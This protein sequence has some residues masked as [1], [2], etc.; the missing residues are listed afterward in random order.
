MHSI[1]PRTLLAIA[2]LAVTLVST[3]WAA[4]LNVC[5]S[6]TYKTIQSAVDSAQSGDTVL[7]Q[8][9]TY[10]EQVIVGTNGLHLLAAALPGQAKLKCPGDPNDENSPTVGIYGEVDQ[11]TVAGFDIS[12]CFNAIVASPPYSEDEPLYVHRW[13]IA[14]NILHGNGVGI[15]TILNVGSSVLS[16]TFYANWNSNVMSFV[17]QQGT[18]AGN[19]VKAQH[20]SIGINL[21]YGMEM[22]VALNV[23]RGATIGIN[24]SGTTDSL[25]TMNTTNGGGVGVWMQSDSTGN[26]ITNSIAKQNNKHAECKVLVDQEALPACADVVDDTEGSETAG[27]ANLYGGDAFG[28]TSSKALAKAAR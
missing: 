7:V 3:S 1:F 9:G 22:L 25:L 28:T 6:C 27:T 14:G 2:I 11:V 21:N 16:N 5:S 17:D 20:D 23:V 24:M 15:A 18:I 13:T 26:K 8:R 4:T 12:N 10:E 19:L